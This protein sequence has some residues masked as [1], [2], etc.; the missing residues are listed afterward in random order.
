MPIIKSAIKKL[1]QDKKRTARSRAQKNR[2]REAVKLARVQPT[3]EN[4][5][6]AQSLLD[7]LAKKNIFHANKSA[8]LKSA[9]AKLQK[10][11]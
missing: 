1:K 7:K 3:V 4:L 11:A 5:K 2:A 9:L 10:T 6:R 8:R